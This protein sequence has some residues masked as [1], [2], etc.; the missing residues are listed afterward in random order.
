M[1]ASWNHA[2]ELSDPHALDME[3]ICNCILIQYITSY[4]DPLKLIK[5]QSLITLIVIAWFLVQKCMLG[6][7]YHDNELTDLHAIYIEAKWNACLF[8]IYIT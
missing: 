5:Y 7:W 6:T 2:I 4:P 1:L 3:V 8:S